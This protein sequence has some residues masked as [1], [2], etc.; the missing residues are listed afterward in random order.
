MYKRQPY[1]D[2]SSSSSEDRGKGSDVIIMSGKRQVAPS[3]VDVASSAERFSRLTIA[4]DL[5]KPVSS[6]VA[7]AR[8]SAID[9]AAVAADA[10]PISSVERLCV[11]T[12]LRDIDRISTL[13]FSSSANQSE[14]AQQPIR[15]TKSCL[16]GTLMLCDERNPEGLRSAT[17][18]L[19]WE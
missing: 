15:T 1:G 10:L 16:S 12:P 18:V 17:W 7:H 4:N 5:A 2:G 3:L 11:T 19:G 8:T 6:N 13:P 14:A 9:A